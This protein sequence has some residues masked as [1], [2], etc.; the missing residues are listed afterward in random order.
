MKKES[1]SFNGSRCPPVT[2]VTVKEQGEHREESFLSMPPCLLKLTSFTGNK[3]KV[4]RGGTKTRSSAELCSN[5]GIVI[6]ITIM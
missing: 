1:E 6:K 2:P 5:F 3:I 4:L